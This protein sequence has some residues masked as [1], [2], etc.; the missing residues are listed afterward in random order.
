MV[1][2]RKGS[3]INK[4]SRLMRTASVVAL[5]PTLVWLAT[6]AQAQL[7]PRGPGISAARTLAAARGV[8][9]RT[10]VATDALA[11]QAAAQTRA[12][13]IRTMATQAKAAIAR[14]VPNGLQGLVVARGVNA[15][16]LADGALAAAR[17]ST[18]RATW[19]GAQLPVETV[20]GS[21][22]TVTVKQTDSRAILSWDRFDV[23]AQTTLQ[24]DQTLNGVGQK[25]WIVVNRV[26]DPRA[27]PSQ[28][29]GQ[30]KAAGTVVAINRNG[31][32]FG[33]TARVNANSLLAS[34][35]DIGNFV[36]FVTNFPNPETGK[37]DQVGLLGTTLQ[38][39]NIA[40]LQDG[41][42]PRDVNAQFAGTITSSFDTGFYK[43]GAL[44]PQFD[45]E[46]EGAVTVERGA[47]ITA[48]TGGFVIF[49][50]PTISNDGAL[51]AEEGQV[52]L[53]AGR[54]IIAS[55]STGAADKANEDPLIRGMILRTQFAGGETSATNSGLIETKRGYAS[56]GAAMDGT[57][58]NAGLITAT[59]SVSRNGAIS[60]TAG[61]VRLAGA[62]DAGQASGLVILPDEGEETIPQGPTGMPDSFKQSQI[63]IGAIY[64]NPRNSATDR[65]GELGPAAID[66]E[67]NSLILA[68]NANVDI[69]GKAG[70]IYSA[71]RYS[72]SG[73]LDAPTTL[74]RSRISIASGALVDVS[75]VKDVTLDPS[76][77]SLK[78]APLKRN[79]LRDTPNYRETNTTGDFTLN[80]AT[81]YVDPRVSGVR[82]DGVAYVGSPLI[83][84][85]SAASQIGVTATELMTRAGNVSLNVETLDAAADLASTPKI[86]IATGATIDF[87]G[88]WVRYLEGYVRTSRLVSPGG[89]LI[90]IGSARP[91]DFY[92]AVGEG[93]TEV[94][95]KFGI[96]RQ[97]DDGILQG[98]HYEASYD[99]GRD[100]GA[101]QIG[102]SN[103]AIDGTL[104]GN[105]F[106]G[107]RQL[108]GGKRGDVV[109]KRAGD[110]RLLQGGISQIPS[111]GLLQIGNFGPDTASVLVG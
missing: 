2:G 43:N 105:A 99:E 66:M 93:F 29:L 37:N 89:A 80:G 33:S 84:A 67:A 8:P 68:P 94:Q 111:G 19:Q 54:A 24:F 41:L 28:I 88:G 103:L 25:D 85:G 76:R 55:V 91:N 3:G 70:Q 18:G 23:G 63:S 86:S 107:A 52:S 77:N 42:L 104:W 38:D 83:E 69:G 11:R 90:D 64:F 108:S 30:I 48:G 65:L 10:A 1:E 31:M 74:A 62:S 60:L 75:G 87:S 106:A 78:I 81:V 50:A 59:T 27:A 32:I 46:I 36:K 97:Y 72:D 16:A 100:A 14:S 5:A 79:E 20:N 21:D 110:M 82:D 35:L 98:L 17:D 96:K 58:T 102:G 12:Q 73:I 34:S 49:T 101:L 51:T 44:N 39:R 109:S 61:T 56:L 47:S 26:V 92:I 7:A 15:Q 57:V 53:Q 4:R 13:Q 45:P 22:F 95:A 40:F 71:T 9:V 6:P